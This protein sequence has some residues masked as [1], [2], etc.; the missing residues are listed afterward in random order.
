MSYRDD[1]VVMHA[2]GTPRSPIVGG[3]DGER[4]Y[5]FLSHQHDPDEREQGALKELLETIAW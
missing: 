1:T 4:A 2:G 5:F 3:A